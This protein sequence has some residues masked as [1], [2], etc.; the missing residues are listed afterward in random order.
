MET[1]FLE[2]NICFSAIFF[3]LG[4]IVG[5]FLNVAILRYNTGLSFVRGRSMCFSCGRELSARDLIPVASYVMLRG[6]CRTCGSKISPQYFSV[7]L[8]TA[9]LFLGVY[10]KE[11]FSL[12]FILYAT[13]LSL[14][15]FIA[16]YDLKHKIIPDGASYALAILAL[17]SIFFEGVH[18]SLPN[19]N[20][21][22]AGIIVALPF[23]L[24]WLVSRGRW[25][26]LGDAKLV[27]SFG[28]FL[29]L[30]LGISAVMYGFW[31]GA[32]WAL[33]ALCWQLVM[34]RKTRLSTN[35]NRLTMK[36]E[37][38]FAPF[39]ILGFTIAYFFSL[40][41]FDLPF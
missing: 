18:L 30:P 4:A 33:S 20:D 34:V 39:L 2:Q 8:L 40:N 37:I 35:R 26:G 17:F 13:A 5:S 11:G 24:L 10:L 22:S 9:I 27:V 25:I 3:I 36:S 29:G 14:F 31:A 21:W 38:P 7:E 32:V 1:L 16:V 23:V 19:A 28:W 6:K 12:T 41:L 15:V